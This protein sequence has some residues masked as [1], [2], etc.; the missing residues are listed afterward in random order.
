MQVISS[1]KQEYKIVDRRYNKKY[2][3]DIVP[4]RVSMDYTASGLSRLWRWR[5]IADIGM[6]SANRALSDEFYSLKD[7][8]VDIEPYRLTRAENKARTKMLEADL[9]AE[10]NIGYVK[11]QGLYEEIK[12]N[13]ETIKTSE[14]S[15]FVYSLNP[16]FDLRDYLVKLGVKYSQDSIL[17]SKANSDTY[18]LVLTNKFTGQIGITDFV[19]NGS[20][21]GTL[22]YITRNEQNEIVKELATIYSNKK[23]R[24]K[25]EK[26]GTS[27]TFW[28]G[29]K[30]VES[31]EAV[32]EYLKQKASCRY[33][34]KKVCDY[35]A[36]ELKNELDNNIYHKRLSMW[37]Q[38]SYLTKRF[39]LSSRLKDNY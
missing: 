39:A 3:V 16:D 11:I 24:D 26:N 28:F 29:V 33:E 18:D 2:P 36:E 31:P 15:F 21:W 4:E 32:A 1:F 19:L 23:Y 12:E 27:K 9:R 17:F 25:S 6:V 20:R 14:D 22:E 5:A 34:V 7:K 37:G 10:K 13:N 35:T 38:E 8:S 30:D